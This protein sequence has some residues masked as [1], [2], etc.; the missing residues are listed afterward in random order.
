MRSVFDW[1]AEHR[2]LTEKPWLILGKG[3]SFSRHRDF[4]LS[5]FATL[6]L[7][8][9]ARELTVDL[10][11]AIDLDVVRRSGPAI[12]RNARVLVMPWH[13]HVG[14]DAGRET[15]EDHARKEPVL[16]ELAKAGRLL[17]YNLSTS[18]DHRSG[19]PVVSARFF[20]A[21]AAL[22]VL[23]AGG[24]RT[25]RSLG[26]DGG[27]AYSGAFD[28]LKDKS[29]LANRRSTFD[30][31]FAEI[32]KTILRTGIDFAPLDV[33][34]PI[35]VYV[36]ATEAQMLAVKVLEYSIRRHA[37]MT[38]EVR[39]L[40]ESGIEIP[41]PRDPNNWP[42][43]P[44]TFQRFL[45]PQITGYSGR[46]IYLDSDMQVFDDVRKLW[47]QPFGGANLL[48]VGDTPHSGRRP[49]FSVMV[50]DCAAL[51]W[52]IADLVRRLDAHELTYEDL[53]YEMRV[54]GKVSAAIPARWNSLESYVEGETSLLHYTD[55][56]TQPW[57]YTGNP[58]GRLW[59]EDLLEAVDGGFI[60]N[61][62]VRNHI[63]QGWVRPSLMWQL[64]HLEPEGLLLPRSA[65]L[66]DKDFVPPYLSMPGHR[67]GRR[68]LRPS[69]TAIARA[70]YRRS[71]LF[72]LNRRIA[73]RVWRR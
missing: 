1:L 42:R 2:A 52:R 40:H 43:T 25:V 32:A 53:V 19:S 30:D 49:Q 71:V 24:V 20:S 29:L 56:D 45:I 55:M 54:A 6:A 22:N 11:H 33:Q 18:A 41:R 16:A 7:N 37:S 5:G 36:A 26:V 3:P 66:L 64:E 8:D 63:A 60:S 21:E 70:L 31:Q 27:A 23:A 51:D 58:N 46:A 72:Q 50:L 69:P 39:S 10:A 15:L 61:E 44:F 4:D 38:V 47:M 73:A 12:A 67:G 57:V 14:F 59:V 13:P 68:K 35:R 34:S 9:S 65:R 28:D 17:W 62:Y 48:A